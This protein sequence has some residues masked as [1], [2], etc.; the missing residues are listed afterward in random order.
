NASGIILDGF[1][2]TIGQAKILE[3]LL[4][5]LGQPEIK[6]LFLEVDKANLIDRI[7]KRGS[8][9]NRADDDASVIEK[10]FDEYQVKT[11]PVKEY[12]EQQNLL[13]HI[14][15]DQPIEVVHQEILNRLGL[16]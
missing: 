10:R 16:K 7:N 13:V 3:N 8:M 4:G 6:V 1:P 12:Y 5:E 11:A 2:R 15:G 9:S 14:N